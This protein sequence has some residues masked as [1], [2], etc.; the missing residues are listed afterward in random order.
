MN[1]IP[2]RNVTNLS[3]SALPAVVNVHIGVNP[4]VARD[5]TGNMKVIGLYVTG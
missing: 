4:S 1:G 3:N 2:S 5:D